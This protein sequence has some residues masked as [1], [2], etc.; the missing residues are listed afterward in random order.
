MSYAISSL[1]GT[2]SSRH[3]G[4]YAFDRLT[5]A[6]DMSGEHSGPVWAIKFSPCGRLMATGKILLLHKDS[7]TRQKGL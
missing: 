3:K 6:Q 1:Q 7:R 4:P 5:L 2:A